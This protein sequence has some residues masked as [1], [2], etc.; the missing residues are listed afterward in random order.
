MNQ[1]KKSVMM[2]LLEGVQTA[3]LKNAFDKYLPA[4]LNESV[5]NKKPVLNE[6]KRE[7]REATG[8]RVVKANTNATGIVKLDEL[9]KLAGIQN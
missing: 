2:D 4:V 1:A 5:Q 8:D 3:Q 6:G 7:V 9:K